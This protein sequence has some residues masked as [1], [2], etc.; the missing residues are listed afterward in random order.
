MDANKNS[1]ISFLIS[2][3]DNN[4]VS[5]HMPGH[6]GAR[7]YRELGYGEVLKRLVDMDVTEI[8]GAD[9]L[10]QP[11]TVIKNIMDRYADYFNNLHFQT[12][13]QNHN[14]QNSDIHN[15]DIQNADIQHSD[16]QSSVIQTF[17]SIGG[18]SSGLIAAILTAV[19]QRQAKDSATP[20]ILIARNCH[21]SVYNGTH[22][23]GAKALYVFPEKYFISSVRE[24]FG[25][26]G[27]TSV[28]NYYGRTGDTSVEDSLEQANNYIAG[29]ISPAVIEN[30]LKKN[31]NICA[32][33]VT[34]PNYYGV[35]SDI[36]EIADICH[37]HDAILIV[38]QAHG[39]H[40]SLLQDIS[41][42]IETYDLPDS[43]S[44]STIKVPAPAEYLGADIVISSTHK[45]LA[46]FT[47]TAIVN[48]CSNRIDKGLLAD[49]LQMVQSSSPSYILMASLEMNIDILEKHG[50]MLSERWI[51]NLNYF[52]HEASKI[53]GV[54]IHFS[55]TSKS[56]NRKSSS[57]NNERVA[58]DFTKILID[59]SRLGYSGDELSHELEKRGIIPELSDSVICMGMTGIGNIR[60][61]YDR[62]LEA[63][64]EISENPK[65]KAEESS[66][67]SKNQNPED[68]YSLSTNQ[69]LE[70]SE[71]YESIRSMIGEVARVSIIPYPPGI[72]LIAAGETI[73]EEALREA[74]R[75]RRAGH[76]V[77][78]LD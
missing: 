24:K 8:P 11:E 71:D 20:K 3:A 65:A 52:Y 32:V 55:P 63:L 72:P 60:E 73:T 37:G 30:A 5:F 6:K 22:L 56:N 2:H 46:S 21:K 33:V 9:N 42:G 67:I 45:T 68:K 47:Q 31:D 35:M 27:H 44:F 39:A 12:V 10:F 34:S 50:A 78:G 43:N 54:T 53:D 26:T 77:L 66:D 4:N 18:S 19:D 23:S 62:L 48:V 51:D 29:A 38:D 76:K 59:M 28:D 49:K 36:K 7:L 64:R 1:L 70:S 74:L 61:D 17:L 57:M 14:N 58:F 69:V 25:Q 40:L 13:D 15:S 16:I 75:L 41:C